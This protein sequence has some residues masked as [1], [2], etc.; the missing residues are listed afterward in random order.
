MTECKYDFDS[1]YYL[2]QEQ[3]WFFMHDLSHWDDG[4]NINSSTSSPEP[5]SP[6]PSSP[7]P[8]SPEPSSPEPSSPEP[9][10]PEPSS[11]EPSSPEPRI[12]RKYKSSKNSSSEEKKYL[13]RESNKLA[14][15]RAREKRAA[16]IKECEHKYFMI[17][18]KYPDFNT[19]IS[20][21]GHFDRRTSESESQGKR[22][23]ISNKNI[24]EDQLKSKHKKRRMQNNI[25]ARYYRLK[26]EWYLNYLL[27]FTQYA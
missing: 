22:T 11:P 25:S 14:A 3:P 6:E 19:I 2:K 24:T 21:S 15:N 8:S 26:R 13:K 18:G 23:Y 1:K 5:S 4:L 9:S 7:E 10:S 12:R 17:T 16:M 20:E 27:N